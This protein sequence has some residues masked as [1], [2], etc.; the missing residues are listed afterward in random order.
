MIDNLREIAHEE[1]AKKLN[2][3]VKKHTFEIALSQ[4]SHSFAENLAMRSFDA[5]NNTC[6]SLSV[7]RDFERS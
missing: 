5:E 2:M 4:L 3:Q 6:A 1:S 7:R